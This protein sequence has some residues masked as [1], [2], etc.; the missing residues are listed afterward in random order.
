MK[1]VTNSRSGIQWSL[2]EQLEDLDFAEDL[3]LLTHTHQQMQDQSHKLRSGSKSTHQKVMWIKNKNNTPITMDQ[4][5]LE[6][7]NSFTDRGSLINIEGGS[8]GGGQSQNW[9][10]KDNI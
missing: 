3:A 5:Q 6:D 8:G 2:T 7:V 4:N 10:S 1:Q 9:E